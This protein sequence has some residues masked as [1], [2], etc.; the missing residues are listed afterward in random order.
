MNKRIKKALY[1]SLLTMIFFSACQKGEESEQQEKE[2]T[3]S[4]MARIGKS[5]SEPRYE[6]DDEKA[7]ANF[8]KNDDIGVFMD[9]GNS[10]RWVFDNTSWTTES[11]IYWEDRD[12]THDF[13]AYYPY[14]EA[15]SKENI[16]MPSLDNQ[17]GKWENIA[18]Y[19]FLVASK[20]LSYNEDHGNVAF[21]GEYSFKHVSSLLKMNIKGEGDMAK[22]VI[23]KIVL[24]GN[25]LVTQGY[26]S[27]KTNSVT[28][29]G[30]PKETLYIAPAHLM[31]SQNVS[32]YFILNGIESDENNAL[33]TTT[34]NPINLTIEYTLNSKKY[35]AQRDGLSPGLLSGRIHEYNI[36][37]K[38]G[39]VII[40]G[41]S[42]SGWTPGNEVEDIIIN[43][44]E[45]TSTNN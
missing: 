44:E 12:K 30:T 11:S 19:D 33:R 27:F 1:I 24:E 21:S 20:S 26:Y 39:N 36:L 7:T 23:D 42:I 22:A 34:D 31:N 10:V 2:Y 4:I 32:F 3:V 13:C 8:I 40:T 29:S 25:D 43:G 35:I 9:D 28:F 41:G 38:D 15:E 5:I 17:V 14:S 16:K 18:R 45:T 37:V 6:Q